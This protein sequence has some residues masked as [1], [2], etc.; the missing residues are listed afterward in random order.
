MSRVSKRKHVMKE[1]LEDNFDHPDPTKKQQIV[2][3]ISSRGNNLHEVETGNDESDTNETFLVSMPMKF[4]NN[5]W[6]KRG[7]FIII[8][9]IEEGNKVRG[10]IVRM[11]SPEHVKEFTKDGIWPIKFAKKRVE[12]TNKDDDNDSESDLVQNT[13]RW[14]AGDESESSEEEDSQTSD[15]ENEASTNKQVVKS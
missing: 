14:N 5:I 3:I 4:R 10:E 6:I 13:N 9:E 7:D 1:M 2:R 8:E 11:L 15:D 12:V